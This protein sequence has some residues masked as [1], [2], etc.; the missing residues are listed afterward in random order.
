MRVARRR[1]ER[2][3]ALDGRDLVRRR[4]HHLVADRHLPGLDAAREDAA[5]VA[6][7][8]ELVDR[9]HRHAQRLVRAR[10][11]LGQRV[12]Q[13]QQRRPL[14]P[15]RLLAAVGEVDA[16]HRRDRDELA[17]L[18]R[19]DALEERAVLLLDRVEVVLAVVDQ[20]H[21]VHAHDDLADAEHR[22]DVAVA[23]AVLAHAFLG[24]DHQ[25]GGLGARRAGD[26]VLQ[27]LDVAG[28]VDDDVVARRALEEAAGGVDRDALV[29]LVRQRVE[30]E[31]VLE[32]L[33]RPL[34]LAPDRF[35]LALR[36]RVRVGEQ[37]ADDR[38]LAVIDVADDDDV[39]VLAF[40]RGLVH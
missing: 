8:G 5:I 12:Q 32:R 9:L 4:E 31:R 16:R 26:H 29:L 2:L 14:V 30:Q 17:R 25:H 6:V 34:A 22:Q 13:L 20:V 23:P 21:L 35:E 15:G 24:V 27:E 39:E 1:V 10:R 3:D 11:R 28:G 18:E 7:L 38:A 37:P 33:A 19:A 40:G 36:Q